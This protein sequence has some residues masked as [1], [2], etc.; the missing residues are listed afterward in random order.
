MLASTHVSSRDG[1]IRRIRTSYGT[2]G[3]AGGAAAVV[4][5]A[6][7][8]AGAFVFFVGFAEAV[9]ATVADGAAVTGGGSGWRV[10]GAGTAGRTT[11]AGAGGGLGACVGRAGVT[12]WTLVSAPGEAYAAGRAEGEANTLTST[13][14]R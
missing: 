13:I 14:A 8:A 4:L 10:T 12:C 1:V 2:T 7:V 11:L 5:A 9:G 3:A 6:L